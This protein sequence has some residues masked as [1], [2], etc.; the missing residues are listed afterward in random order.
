[1]KL[2]TKLDYP[3]GGTYTETRNMSV[4]Q[5]QGG[6]PNN[7]SQKHSPKNIAF[8]STVSRGLYEV[9]KGK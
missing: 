4:K 2:M 5:L 6:S 9:E 8:S 3:D 1:M 7:F